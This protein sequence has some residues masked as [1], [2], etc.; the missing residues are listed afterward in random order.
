MFINSNCITKRPKT[1]HFEEE[2]IILNH[3]LHCNEYNLF[4]KREKNYLKNCQSAR[5]F[6]I[7]NLTKIEIAI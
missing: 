2:L 3:T 4:L 1:K 7:K 5:K 6:S